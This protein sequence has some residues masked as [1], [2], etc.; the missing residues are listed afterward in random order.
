MQSACPW[1]PYIFWLDRLDPEEEILNKLDMDKCSEIW[2]WDRSA[3]LRWNGNLLDFFLTTW[4]SGRIPVAVG[5]RQLAPFWEDVVRR[6]YQ[7]S[8]WNYILRSCISSDPWSCLSSAP[9]LQSP[10]TRIWWR[11]DLKNL[12]WF[13]KIHVIS[14]DA[15][16]EIA[17][18]SVIHKSCWC[19]QW[20]QESDR[21]ISG[22]KVS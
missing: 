2:I 20:P 3:L 15:G 7:H 10:M 1:L 8:T 11:T 13:R 9:I 14:P 5:R 6:P 12:A 18:N 17:E 4:Y 19:F 22:H 16:Q 21:R